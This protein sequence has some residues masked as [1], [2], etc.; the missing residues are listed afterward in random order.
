MKN[1]KNNAHKV[2]DS[3]GGRKEGKENSRSPKSQA[4]DNNVT[5]N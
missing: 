3:K 5:P 1:P 2:G 4:S